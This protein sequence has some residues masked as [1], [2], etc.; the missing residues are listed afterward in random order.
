MTWW[1]SFAVQHS[2]TCSHRIP[3]QSTQERL[4]QSW[5]HQ[6]INKN[7]WYQCCLESSCSSEERKITNWGKLNFIRWLISYTFTHI[8]LMLLWP[9][10]D[11]EIKVD[12]LTKP[13]SLKPLKDKPEDWI[14]KFDGTSFENLKNHYNGNILYRK[15]PSV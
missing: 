2:F 3:N 15:K 10:A 11:K 7:T 12:T 13:T 8:Q 1:I 9:L 4:N 14:E 6:K 5:S